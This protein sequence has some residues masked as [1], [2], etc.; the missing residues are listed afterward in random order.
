MTNFQAIILQNHGIL[1]ACPSIEST[2]AYYIT[3]ERCCQVQLLVDAAAAS[4][5]PDRKPKIIPDE[6]AAEVWKTVGVPV[7]GSF[8]GLCLLSD[9]ENREGV[10]FQ[11]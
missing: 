8:S 3:L 4:G 1:V 10:S 11:L 5:R 2:L 6:E 7:K 9:L